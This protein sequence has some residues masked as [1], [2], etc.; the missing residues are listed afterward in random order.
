[1][2]N[3]RLVCSNIQQKTGINKRKE[4]GESNVSL[5]NKPEGFLYP[6]VHFI[7]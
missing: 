6:R 2:V 3:D 7:Y 1:M 5:W 4:E